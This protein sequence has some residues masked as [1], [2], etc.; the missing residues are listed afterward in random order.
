M[1]STV[2]QAFNEF[3]K[4][5]VNLD[6]EITKGAISSRDW[7]INQIANFKSKESDFP[8]PYGEINISF[9]SFAR[10]TKIKELDD[11]D[12][13]IGLSGQGSSY[14]TY[15]DRI[16]ITVSGEAVNLLKLCHSNSKSLNSKRVIN[17]FVSTCSNVPQYSRAEIKR[18]QEAAVLNLSSYPWSFDIVPC[19]ITSEDLNGKSYYLIPDGNGYWKKT[20]PRIDKERTTRINQYHDGSIL[21][22]IRILKYWNRKAAMPT[23]S[24]Y[25]LETMVLNYY[26]GKISKAGQF[27]DIEFPNVIAYIYHNILGDVGDPKGI[28]G[29]INNLTYDE[30][31]K[32]KNKTAIDYSVSIAARKFEQNKD[33]KSS[34]SKWGEVFGNEFPKYN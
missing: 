30:R 28:Q 6:S 23:M 16:E 5:T 20:D 2:I 29:N 11:I 26:K 1:A 31:T 8:T 9:G 3:M 13:M 22:V 32:V 33:M 17:K 34:I 21:Q 27:V 15:S 10:K 12:I 4:D 25:L 19:F 7:L 18:N 24:S 14:M